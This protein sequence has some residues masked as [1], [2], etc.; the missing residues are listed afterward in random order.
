MARELTKKQKGFVKDYVETGNGSL[1]AK[2]NYDVEADV[3]ARSIASENLTKP[4]IVK[5]IQDAL[6]DDL[7]AKNHLEL[8]EQK[9]TDYFVF[10][11]KMSDEEIIDHV[12]AAGFEVIVV[13]ESDRGKLA[14][15]SVADANAKGKALDMAYKIKGTYAPEKSV[16][17][18]LEIENSPAIKALSDKFD[19]F[20]DSQLKEDTAR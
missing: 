14:F 5:A 4:N 10:S 16:S 2:K 12:K 6:G 18:N 11:S 20:M 19:A 1:A 7:L 8:L 15:Y 9:R 3:T 17:L 13:R